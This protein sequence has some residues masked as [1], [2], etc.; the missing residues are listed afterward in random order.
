MRNP[1]GS[2]KVPV[3]EPRVDALIPRPWCD[4]QLAQSGLMIES[5]TDDTASPTRLRVA[6]WNLNHWRQP[7]LPL[8]TRRGA[9]E[10]LA[11]PMGVQVAL[12]QEG[13][14]P[15]GLARERHVFGELSGYRAWG[16][17]VVALDPGVLIE[18]I[19]SVRMPWS[20]RRYR[21]DAAHPGSTAVARVTVDGLQP[22]T[23]VSVYGVL[24]GSALI[25]MHQIVADLLPLF[26]SPDGARVFLGGD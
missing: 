24:E 7:L 4:R 16:S 11:G 22:I 1:I 9:W 8:D 15:A 13:V 20:K 3:S 26:D 25:S 14:P 2:T 10:H 19:R 23:L 12:V 6:T 21:L 17:G 18:P 5:V